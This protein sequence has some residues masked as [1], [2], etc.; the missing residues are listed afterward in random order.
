M[1]VYKIWSLFPTGGAIGEFTQ[2]YKRWLL[3][4]TGRAI[5]VVYSLSYVRAK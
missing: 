3:F 5:G 4:L 1:Q 2:V